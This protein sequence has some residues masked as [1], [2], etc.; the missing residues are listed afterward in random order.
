[1]RIFKDCYQVISELYREVYEMGAIVKPKSMQNF[2]V[3]GNDD[4]ITKE[5]INYSYCLLSLDRRE[6]LFPDPRSAEW[7]KSEFNERVLGSNVNPGN[8][9]RL[10]PELWSPML[11]TKPD[12]DQGHIRKFDYTYNERINPRIYLHSIINELRRNPDT[13]QAVLSIWD[14]EDA[15]AI[16]GKKR[17]PCSIYY[18]FLLREGKLNI[19]YNQRSAD[20]VTHF[21][22]DIYLAWSM[23]LYVANLIEVEP[24]YLYHNIASLHSYKKDWDT[25]KTCIEKNENQS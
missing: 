19:I 11:V 22:N 1:M 16:G 4:F 10:R 24:G 5:I 12:A 23:M 14:R 7:V 15:L 25:L 20:V 21:G 6:F 17:V 8:A 9:W 18:Q 3:E 2:N 13:R